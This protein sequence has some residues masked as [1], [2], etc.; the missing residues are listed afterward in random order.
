MCWQTETEPE[1]HNPPLY[2]EDLISHA[3]SNR[4]SD[5]LNGLPTPCS[6]SSDRETFDKFLACDICLRKS[7]IYAA[8][9]I[10]GISH[11]EREQYVSHKV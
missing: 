1:H 7:R 9:I 10:Q 2:T 5:E 6:V 3:R 4:E 11:R 8:N